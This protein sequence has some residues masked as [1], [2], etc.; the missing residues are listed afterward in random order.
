MSNSLLDQIAE[1]VLYEGYVLYPYRPSSGKNQRQRFMFGRVY[2]EEYS[3]AQRAAEP[4]VMQTECLA[5]FTSPAAEVRITV[6]FLQPLTR[7]I[8]VFESP[9]ASFPQASTPPFRSVPELRVG[10]QLYQAWQEAMERTVEAPTLLLDPQSLSSTEVPFRFSGARDLEPIRDGNQV[11]GF[12]SRTHET[13]QGTVDITSTPVGPGLHQL[14]VRISNHTPLPAPDAQD[15]EAVSLRTFASTHTILSLEG[16]EFLSL[17]DPPADYQDEARRCRNLGTWPVLVGDER[18]GERNVMLSAPII[19]Y[20]FPQIAPESAGPFFDG[21]EIDE[22]LALRIL[23]M[24][25]AEKLEMRH[26]DPHVRRLL[27]RTETL[28]QETLLRLHGTMREPERT[29]PVEYD[30][31]FGAQTRLQSVLVQGVHLAAGDRVRICPKA[32]ADVMDLALKGRTA[33]IEA[34]EQDLEQRIHLALVLEQDP[35]KDLGLLRQP[36]HRFFYGVDEVEPLGK[37]EP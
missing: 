36:G 6:R 32:R 14:T 11:V 37:D 8:G 1:A 17:M 9:L 7:G 26:V 22:M 20:D 2:P 35:G 29:K 10:D 30:D 24:T 21:T 25:D 3:L 31:F 19:L 16:G 27:E 4:F 13:L 33:I 34:V 23:T 12:I 15:P 28:P 18:R 5:R